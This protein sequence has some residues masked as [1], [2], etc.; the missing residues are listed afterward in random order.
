MDVDKWDNS[1][2]D[3]DDI[4]VNE[5]SDDEDSK[6]NQA[7]AVVELLVKMIEPIMAILRGTGN[8]S[9]LKTSFNEGRV[10]PLG[11]TKLRACEL[12]QSIISL[13]K[14]N[15]IVAVGES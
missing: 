15:V 12:L 4:I 3:D 8:E 11:R 6:N 13:K 1:G 10:L 9:P 7:A 2:D 14:S 5:V